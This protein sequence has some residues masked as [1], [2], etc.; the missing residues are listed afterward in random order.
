V[1]G[2]MKAGYQEK[3]LNIVRNTVELVFDKTHTPQ[4]ITRIAETDWLIQRKNELLCDK[5]Q[6]I[7]GPYNNFPDKMNAIREQAPEIYDAILNMG[8]SKAFFEMYEKIKDYLG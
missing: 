5:Y 7:T 2:L 4:P 3:E 6:E 1:E 8:K